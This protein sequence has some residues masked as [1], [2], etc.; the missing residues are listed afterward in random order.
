MSK[1]D[2]TSDPLANGIYEALLAA[3]IDRS[4]IDRGYH[5]IDYAQSGPH[6][7]HSGQADGIIDPREVYETALD[8]FDRHPEDP[9]YRQ[10][11]EGLAG[12]PVP[13]SLDDSNAVKGYNGA[14]HPHMG[15]ATAGQ[16][17]DTVDA[18]KRIVAESAT[19]P[20]LV[21]PSYHPRP[22][23]WARLSPYA[24]DL[25]RFL[26]E[27]EVDARV[28]DELIDAA[29][30][31]NP[32][33]LAPGE[34]PFRERQ[35]WSRLLAGV[36]APPG[37]GSGPPEP[38]QRLRLD[39]LQFDSVDPYDYIMGAREQE[40]H[41]LIQDNARLNLA[42]RN[43]ID[44]LDTE[45]PATEAAKKYLLG[46]LD[47]NRLKV[48]A[49]LA[50]APAEDAPAT[51]SAETFFD[52]LTA[53]VISRSKVTPAYQ[54]AV[55]GKVE[56]FMATT[57]PEVTGSTEPA[58]LQED[59]AAL[60]AA[61]RASWTG[62]Y[63]DAYL[64]SAPRNPLS[65]D[66]N[67]PAALRWRP[68]APF[69]TVEQQGLFDALVPTPGRG[70]PAPLPSLRRLRFVIDTELPV[71]LRNQDARYS[72]SIRDQLSRVRFERP[73]R[74]SQGDFSYSDIILPPT[75]ENALNSSATRLTDLELSEE[76]L[77]EL[78]GEVLFTNA[79]VWERLRD[80]LLTTRDQLADGTSEHLIE[81]FRGDEW[82]KF[83]MQE[84]VL[85]FDDF[86]AKVLRGL[87]ERVPLSHLADYLAENN[88]L[89]E[90]N[91]AIHST[92]EEKR[93]I[94]RR[95][96]AEL[97]D[98]VIEILD[99]T[100]PLP[101]DPA[102]LIVFVARKHLH[103]AQLI[104]FAE[105]FDQYLWLL[106]NFRDSLSDRGVVPNNVFL[107]NTRAAAVRVSAV[108]ARADEILS[109]PEDPLAAVAAWPAFQDYMAA[110][111]E[112]DP[113]DQ[114]APVLFAFLFGNTAAREFYAAMTDAPP[115]A[116]LVREE[117]L[118]RSDG[119]ENEVLD[120]L[121]PAQAEALINRLRYAL[122][123]ARYRVAADEVRAQRLSMEVDITVEPKIL[124][125]A[126]ESLRRFSEFGTAPAGDYRTILPP[127]AEVLSRPG[128]FPDHREYFTERLKTADPEAADDVIAEMEAYLAT[129]PTDA[130]SAL[131][132]AE[133]SSLIHANADLMRRAGLIDPVLLDLAVN[134]IPNPLQVRIRDN[135]QRWR[136]A[137]DTGWPHPN[138]SSPFF[139]ADAPAGEEAFR[140]DMDFLPTSDFHLS[141]EEFLDL[142]AGLRPNPDE[143]QGAIA[144]LSFFLADYDDGYYRYF[145][146]IAFERNTAGREI[147]GVRDHTAYNR[148]L[149]VLDDL[150]P[151]PSTWWRTRPGS[152]RSGAP[153]T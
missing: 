151:T 50:G 74:A 47:V 81:A 126:W 128:L 97:V 121:R 132:P 31:K 86:A 131:G 141:E 127:L 40:I 94:F 57:T 120:F 103:P 147:K 84:I 104:A 119:L 137:L 48:M 129:L 53:Q 87:Q 80:R 13:Q 29:L 105:Y 95:Q 89:L 73:V 148:L 112:A 41:F 62:V 45:M 138:G 71:F 55:I 110:V 16:Q 102:P 70:Q 33:Y 101:N 113:N 19:V 25:N 68:A 135:L 116:W 49:A 109:L 152:M 122:Y 115:P 35:P 43:L 22:R 123:I 90:K 76:R 17:T 142:L 83:R 11:V 8:L 133:R 145:S 28:R 140:P 26:A 149:I 124:A 59:V 63:Y 2:F 134:G 66:G 146:P 93:A 34:R 3:G 39:P 118:K 5:T 82:R 37:P 96:T 78:T 130:G 32:T 65:P 30:L 7:T 139:A 15:Q 27:K 136:E 143:E 125:Q 1:I 107:A 67:L 51:G 77:L 44:A 153:I 52:T 23:D 64:M 58:Q 98:A 108:L 79:P 91:F 85:G 61:L 24:A 10:I 100:V 117:M 38:V 106:R 144:R 72:G 99:D 111:N 36:F 4:E 18:G 69:D 9:R 54:T 60:G 88:Q 6:E 92:P 46:M 114:T 56:T 20:P 42:G 12:R 14:A 21:I 150:R 75:R